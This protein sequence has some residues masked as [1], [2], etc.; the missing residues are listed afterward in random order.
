M[1]T[2]FI[3]FRKSIRIGLVAGVVLVYLSLTGLIETFAER[4][5]IDDVISLGNALLFMPMFVAGYI[6]QRHAPRK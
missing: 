1:Q 4:S 5:L 6:H 3:D 2:Q